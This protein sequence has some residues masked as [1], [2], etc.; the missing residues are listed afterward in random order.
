MF[1][2][3]RAAWVLPID[4]PPLRDGWVATD[5]GRIVGVGDASDDRGLT[6]FA[7]R[8]TSRVRPQS[9]AILPGLI[10]AHTHLELSWMA[11]KVPPSTSI[12][13]WIRQLMALRRGAPPSEDAQRQAAARAIADALARGTVAFGD[14][15]NSLIAA[16]VLADACVPAVVFHE[17]IGFGPAGARER[18][19]AGAHHVMQAVRPPVRAGLA[20]HAPYSVSPDLFRA[21]ADEAAAHQLPSSVHLGESREEIEFL[22]TG[23]GD[24]AETLKQL[25]AWNDGW[26]APGV[27]PAEYLDRLGVL[28]PGL[29][30][31][32][33]T[34]LKLPA[35]ARLA[36]R[37]CVIISCPR[38]NQWV[39]AGDPPLDDFYASGAAVA[40]GTDSLAS[41]PDLDM[42]A[43][44]AAARAISTVPARKLLESATLAA[45]KALGFEAD[46]GSITIGKRGELIAVRI[47]ADVDNVEEYLVGGIEPS[48]IVRLGLA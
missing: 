39:G 21:V 20:P 33:A 34:Q 40:F 37:G 24:I 45:A 44:L 17:L 48:A 2:L 1:H 26:S 31:V 6:S 22:M 47:P 19:S 11:G 25:G 41:A 5:G 38:S 29:L 43:E 35:L 42:F 23:R 12:G 27:D 8:A 18:A 15:G 7:Q 32:H 36:D 16:D 13:A 9:L 3:Y 4:R 28:R 10:N 14:I 46:L 30:T